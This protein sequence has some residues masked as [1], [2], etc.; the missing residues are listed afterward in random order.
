MI[1]IVEQQNLI[2]PERS[3]ISNL[4]LSAFGSPELPNAYLHYYE[5]CFDSVVGYAAIS[6]RNI[7]ICGTQYNLAFLG[8]V[9]IDEVERRKG[10]GKLLIEYIIKQL[11]C[12]DLDGIIL[13]CGIGVVDFYKKMRFSIISNNACYIRNG[14]IETDNDPVMYFG[15]K[16]TNIGFDDA[17]YFGT[18]F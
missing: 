17:I 10:Y 16:A 9:C 8:F 1:S 11:E 3:Q 18:D 2:E 6:K 14:I 5:K 15:I 4:L 13:N 12:T 7:L